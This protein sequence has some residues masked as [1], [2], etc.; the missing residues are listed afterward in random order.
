MH[1]PA[2]WPLYCC[3]ETSRLLKVNHYMLRARIK[4]RL[5]GCA[6]SS[7]NDDADTEGGV[8]RCFDPGSVTRGTPCLTWVCLQGDIKASIHG[9]ARSVLETTSF[10]YRDV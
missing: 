10:G 8:V 4:M 5:G 6:A 7:Q 2:R 1:S 3:S 9:Q